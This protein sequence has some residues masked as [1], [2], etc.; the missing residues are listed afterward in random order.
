[1]VYKVYKKYIF[2]IY[3]QMFFSRFYI[4]GI[5]KVYTKRGGYP[6]FINKVIYGN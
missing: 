4:Y 2:Y 1:M 3:K 5:Y 6:T